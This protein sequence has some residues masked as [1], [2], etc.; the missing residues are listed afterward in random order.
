MSACTCVP[1]CAEAAA[2]SSRP[3]DPFV[4][5]AKWKAGQTP[6]KVKAQLLYSLQSCLHYSQGC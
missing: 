3:A 6:E 5:V 1:V 4:P 2:G